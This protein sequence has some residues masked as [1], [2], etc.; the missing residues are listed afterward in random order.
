MPPTAPDVL[1]LVVASATMIA[2]DESDSLSTARTRTSPPA[3]LAEPEVTVEPVMSASMILSTVMVELVRAMPIL[4][5]EL[6]FPSESV[7]CAV[8]GS[9]LG[10]T[11]DVERVELS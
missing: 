9:K 6:V 11:E 5:A 3:T 8:A 7:F 4:T 10:A 1:P 2:S